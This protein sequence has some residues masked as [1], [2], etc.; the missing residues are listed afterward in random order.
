MR[1]CFARFTLI[2]FIAVLPLCTVWLTKSGAKHLQQQRIVVRR[3]WRVEEPV[4][5]VAVRTKNQENIELG[6]AF[7]DDND[8]LDGFTVTV[9]NNYH[10]TITAM[11]INM[12]F[13][14][15]PG[16]GRPPL[17]KELHFGPSPIAREYTSRDPNKVIKVGKS[18]N[19]HL[20]A[21]HYKTLK[22]DFEETGYANN[23][24]KVELVITEVGFEDG[25]VFDSGTFYLQDPAYTTDPTRKFGCLS[26]LG[27]PLKTRSVR[28]D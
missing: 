10:K 8:W 14:R 5:I 21:H 12:V 4:K 20:N 28:T 18:A 26:L 23:I 9:A 1:R 3:P 25:S 11:T 22:R 27:R 17:A 15:E 24:T 2:T 7:E 6:K 13:R 16:D 19:L